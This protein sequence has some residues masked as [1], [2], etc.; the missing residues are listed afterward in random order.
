MNVA[1][2]P[3]SARRR[4]ELDPFDTRVIAAATKLPSCLN[5]PEATPQA[6]AEFGCVDWYQ[7][8]VRMHESKK[9]ALKKVPAAFM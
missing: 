9:V 8:P 4:C 7:Y 1:S 5:A 2:Q 3:R 6:E